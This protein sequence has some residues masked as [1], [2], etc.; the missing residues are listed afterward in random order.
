MFYHLWKRLYEFS[1]FL[2]VFRSVKQ[3]HLIL[4]EKLQFTWQNGCDVKWLSADYI[5]WLR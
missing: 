3:N 5:S 4:N 2:F 1:F